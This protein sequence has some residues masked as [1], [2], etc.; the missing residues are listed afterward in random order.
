M[1]KSIKNKMLQNFSLEGKISDSCQ[2][3]QE[4]ENVNTMPLTKNNDVQFEPFLLLPMSI[5]N[6]KK[7]VFDMN[8]EGYILKA[9]STINGKKEEYLNFIALTSISDRVEKSILTKATYYDFTE[10]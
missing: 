7:L 6:T 3:I 2:K 10:K 9:S 1:G 5:T 4:Q 8:N